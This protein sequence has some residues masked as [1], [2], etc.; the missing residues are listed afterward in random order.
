MWPLN[1]LAPQLPFG[2]A[3]PPPLWE[4]LHS[5]LGIV[6]S[7]ANPVHHCSDTVFRYQHHTWPSTKDVPG[8]CSFCWN[9][10]ERQ[11]TERVGATE[12]KVWIG[13]FNVMQKKTTK[14]IL[15]KIWRSLK[16]CKIS[17]KLEHPFFIICQICLGFY[18]V[19]LFWMII[20]LIRVSITLSTENLLQ[21]LKLT[22]LINITGFSFPKNSIVWVQYLIRQANIVVACF[23]SI[24]HHK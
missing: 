23:V 2:L 9:S 7:F 15:Q 1:K 11:K 12:S 6:Y 3:P 17:G 16:F 21:W 22:W 13:N 5:L 14:H 18:I 8:A 4:I 10:V 20:L 24:F 19:V